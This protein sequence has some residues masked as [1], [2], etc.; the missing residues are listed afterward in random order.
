MV[1]IYMIDNNSLCKIITVSIHL[2]MTND[3]D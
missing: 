3:T 2:G 1:V